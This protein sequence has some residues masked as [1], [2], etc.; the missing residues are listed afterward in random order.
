M[1]SYAFFQGQII[2]LEDAK[3]PIM[4]HF[5]HYGTAVF[6]GIRGNWNDDEKQT[7]VFRLREHFE[8]LANGC[9]V[10]KMDIKYSV[11]DLC[12]RTLELVEKCNFETDVYIR[13]VAYTSSQALGVRLHNLEHDFFMFVMPWG[14]YLDVDKARCG[15]STWQRRPSRR[16]ASI[17]TT[18]SPRP[19]PKATASTRPSCSP[20]TATCPRAAARTCSSSSTASW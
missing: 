12:V 19:R 11:D 13:P 18:P 9:R 6:E 4:T 10:L 14:P 7:Y 16:P 3:L 1:P 5:L 8:R 2:P 17:S 20:R 15:V